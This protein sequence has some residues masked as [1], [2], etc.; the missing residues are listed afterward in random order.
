MLNYC[1]LTNYPKN[2]EHLDVIGFVI[3]VLGHDNP[4][5]RAGLKQGD[6]ITKMRDKRE[7]W[8]K[9][10]HYDN[11][12]AIGSVLSE[13]NP[14]YKPSVEIEYI[15]DPN[16]NC[17]RYYKTLIFD[18]RYP[19][20]E[21]HNT[22]SEVVTFLGLTL[23]NDMRIFQFTFTTENSIGVGT[24]ING[25]RVNYSI[26]RTDPNNPNQFLGI[27]VSNSRQVFIQYNQLLEVGFPLA[28]PPRILRT[29]PVTNEN[30]PTMELSSPQ[31]ITY[32]SFIEVINNV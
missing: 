28:A 22:M 6:I 10:G 16:Y 14:K 24:D 15:P 12:Y 21:Q 4:F 20:D 8:V 5:T 26:I 2:Y 17:K 7:N 9:L 1:L 23:T 3:D 32:Q 19:P 27:D 13:Y 11:Y 30:V 25:N 29:N 31:G 18:E